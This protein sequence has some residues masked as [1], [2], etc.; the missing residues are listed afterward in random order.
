MR[1]LT[2]AIC[3]RVLCRENVLAAIGNRLILLHLDANGTTQRTFAVVPSLL[4][5]IH[6]IVACPLTES[7]YQVVFH[8]GP[9]VYN[10]VVDCS[11]HSFSECT[12]IEVRED[13]Q[14]LPVPHIRRRVSDW[15]SSVS[16]LS[17]TELC[18]LTSH[19]VAVLLHRSTEKPTEWSMIDKCACEDGSTL[20]CSTLSG[21]QWDRLVCFTGTALGLL[22]IWRV[23]GDNRGKVM[24]RKSAHN[25][26][27][28]SIACDFTAGV[29][30]TT[31][32]DRSVKFWKIQRADAKDDTSLVELHEERYC[33]AHTA[34]VFQCRIIK[35]AFR[36]LVATIGEDSHL[37]LWNREG[38][39]LLKKQLDEGATLWGM[40]YDPET[41][42]IFVTASNGNVHKYSIQ[43]WMEESQQSSDKRDMNDISPTLADG[44]HLAKIRFIPRNGSLVAVTNKHSVVTLNSNGTV[45]QTIAKIDAFKCSILDV[46]ESFLYLAGGCTVQLYKVTNEGLSELITLKTIFFEDKMLLDEHEEQLRD[47]TIR[48][49]SYCKQSRNVAICDGYGRCLIYDE[50]L[51]NVL[52]KHRIPKSPERWVTSFAVPR[53]GYFLL[54]DRSGHFYLFGVE[55]VQPLCR[56][57]NVHGKLGITSIAVEAEDGDFGNYRLTTTGHDGRICELYLS[58]NGPKLELLTYSKTRISWIDRTIPSGSQRFYLGFNDSHFLMTDERNEI[59]CQFDCGGGHRCWDFFY[60]DRL[61]EFTF[62]FIQHKK[63]KRM[64]ITLTCNVGSALSL[65][66]HKWHTRACNV[67]RVIP[68]S[69]K[70]YLLVSGGEDNI[71]RM[72]LFANGQLLEEPRKHIFSH[73]SGIKTI[74]ASPLKEDPDRLLVISAGGRAQICLTTVKMLSLGPKQEYEYMLLASDAERCR[75]KT[76]RQSSY[77]PETKFMCAARVGEER[78]VFGCSDGFVRIYKLNR[79]ESQWSVELETETFY[80]RCVLQTVPIDG[81]AIEGMF[82]TMATDGFLCFWDITAPNEPVY[83]HRH[84]SSGMNSVDVRIDGTGSILLATGGDD[85]SVSVSQFE[86]TT[87]DGRRQVRHVAGLCEKYLHTAQVTGIKLLSSDRLISAGV[88]QRIYTSSF[89]GFSALTVTGS[90]STCVADV[91]GISHIPERNELI[92]YG[93][94]IEVINLSNL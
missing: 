25:G 44:E 60:D 94:G 50:T 91:K 90:T 69:D 76:N 58:T 39:L 38:D 41:T 46:G 61:N 32:D 59:C 65:P 42:T 9:A 85:Q 73:I 70:N 57:A 1:V 74:I 75:W 19:G 22:L 71:L 21:Q 31:S 63:L 16:L 20:Y 15:I 62:V 68:R 93:C 66:R 55:R 2:D 26:V 23:T 79:T 92:V 56:L 6:G 47:G 81:C 45:I 29:L 87:L 14:P 53:E 64:Q 4:D 67:L 43:S 8:A 34:R 7:T 36:L 54:A 33:F 40:D 77:D 82:V 13:V 5:K 52:S 27:I 10:T 11:T 28:F 78:I 35:N 88:D 84:H 80:G 37:C 30:T 24:E 18:L 17:P 48:S 89:T 51:S 83:R 12:R 49:L 72:N 3:V 86:V